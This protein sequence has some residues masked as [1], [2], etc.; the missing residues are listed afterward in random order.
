MEAANFTAH[1]IELPGGNWTI[2]ANEPVLADFSQTKAVV[3][4]LKSQF[5]DPKNT[6]VVDLGCLEG[7]YA[8]EFARNGF[9]SLGV[10][11]RQSNFE[12]CQFVQKSLGL[13][14]LRFV[15][16]DVRNLAT[17]G[18]FDATFCCGLFYHLDEPASF[19]KLL[20]SQTKKVLI[21]QTHYARAFDPLYDQKPLQLAARSADRFGIDFSRH[22]YRLS[23]LV[24]HDGVRGRW[25]GEFQE[26]TSESRQEKLKW[27]S[28]KNPKSFW[29][30]KEDLIEAMRSAGFQTV[31]EQFDHVVDV[32]TD[33]LQ[34]RHD[35]S[36]FIGIKS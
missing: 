9:Q 30:V 34:S 22:N 10:E 14:N 31:M 15:R 11:V 2:G 28:W 4:F 7:G 20:A 24:K 36:L 13:D 25:F 29:I 35:R 12:N 16:D 33:N 23:K 19:L 5:P 21:L 27:A 17:H 1:N 32:R 6:Q 3:R 18:P 8:V 26:E